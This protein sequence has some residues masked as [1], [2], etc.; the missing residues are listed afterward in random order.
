MKAKTVL[1]MLFVVLIWGSAFPL[2]KAVL[3]ETTPVTL[4]F[5]RFLIATP[6]LVLY[7]QLRRGRE[8]WRTFTQSPLLLA[9]M[10][11]TGVMGYHVLQNLAAKVTSPTNQSIIIS[12]NPIMVTLLSAVLLKEKIGK[13]KI[14][15]IAIGFTGVLL[16]VLSENPLASAISS[17]FVGELLNI[18]AAFSWAIY[19]VLSKKLTTSH[20]AIELTANSMVFGTV[21][22][23]PVAYLY[24]D[25][26]LPT[27]LPVWLGIAV[28]SLVSSCLAYALWNHLLSQEDASKV[29]IS[30]FLIPVVSATISVALLAEPLS[31]T[32]I[33]GMVLVIVGVLIAERSRTS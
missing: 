27:S 22:F 12:S 2:V 1:L 8:Y 3:V 13:N 26:H 31:S 7:A 28:L 21:F 15:G 6:I 16:I 25:P 17:S 11:L 29:S 14:L 4:G 20:T 24:E 19:C 9:L 33:I 10:G 18:G 32:V 23:L 30:L 5:I